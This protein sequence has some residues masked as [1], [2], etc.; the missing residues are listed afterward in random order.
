MRRPGGGT[1]GFAASSGRGSAEPDA[2]CALIYAHHDVQP[3][4]R[5][6]HWKSPP[7][8]PTLGEDGRLHGRGVPALQLGLED[9][10]CNA[11]G[12]NE[13]LHVGG[14]RNAARAA[15]HLL[16]ELR[17]APPPIRLRAATARAR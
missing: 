16:E 13:S 8:E 12:E 7:F 9:P 5:L 14:F 11:H 15:A 10:P 2:P 3:S 17:S 6:E 1:S 4:G